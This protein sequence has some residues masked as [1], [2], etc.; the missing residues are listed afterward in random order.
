MNRFHDPFWI[1]IYV[2][3][4]GLLSFVSTLLAKETRGVSFDVVDAEP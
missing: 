1:T 3:A 2:G 4:A